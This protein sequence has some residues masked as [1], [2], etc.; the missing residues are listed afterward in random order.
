MYGQ[1]EKLRYCEE[2]PKVF[3]SGENVELYPDYADYLLGEVDLALGLDYL[4]DELFY[5]RFPFWIMYFIPPNADY[6][7]VKSKLH[8]M[9]NYS[10]DFNKE[11]SF[12]TLISS[13][14]RNGIRARMSDLVEKAGPI[15]YAGAFRN[16]TRDLRRK[17][18]N[19]KWYYLSLFK[20]NICPE[21][22]N[23]NGYVS[24]KLF[25]SIMT[26]CVPIYWGSNNNPEPEILNQDAIIFYDDQGHCL[27]LDLQ[28]LN[29]NTKLYRDFV[30]Q[31]RFRPTAAEYVW[32]KMNEL[33]SR[34]RVIKRNS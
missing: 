2:R 22:S 20:F 3:F 4:D 33:E 31:E 8:S 16:N 6:E 32:D 13:H 23:K 7:T 24:E 14:D 5:L 34:F 28:E 17:F 18:N 26:G 25:E 15:T 1:R 12:C 29:T 10:Y 27:S 30:L 11:R 9:A 19:S 21:N